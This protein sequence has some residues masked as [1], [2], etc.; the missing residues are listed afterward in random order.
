[1]LRLKQDTAEK[2]LSILEISKASHYPFS[3][4]FIKGLEEMSPLAASTLHAT[5]C[6]DLVFEA[7]PQSIEA[8]LCEARMAFNS[9]CPIL[10]ACYVPSLASSSLDVNLI[11]EAATFTCHPLTTFLHTS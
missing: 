1:L 7:P 5:T 6:S 4:F 11:I 9:S 10:R 2:I 8:L 3:L